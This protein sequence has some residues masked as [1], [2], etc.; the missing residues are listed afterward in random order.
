MPKTPAPPT[1][2]L[3]RAIVSGH[4][5]TVKP[6]LQLLPKDTH[7]SP[8]I[9]GLLSRPYKPNQHNQNLQHTRGP[10][11]PRDAVAGV[12][13]QAT[14]DG[15]EQQHE[16]R[17]DP[18]VPLGV[19][20][21]EQLRVAEQV[22]VDAGQHDAGEGV[23]LEGAAGDGLAARLEGH[24]RDGH[25]DVPGDLVLGVAAGAE[26]H[27]GGGG[28]AQRRLER[29]AGDERPAPLGA[30]AAVEPAEEEGADAEA[31]ERG[32]GLDPPGALRGRREAEPDVDGVACD[33]SQN[34]CVSLVV[35]MRLAE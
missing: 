14:R 5:N 23:V 4:S 35:C 6:R 10:Q 27:D 3:T 20:E 7:P 29:E 18:A 21:A 8:S 30:E 12:R 2:A 17:A 9:I 33:A 11:R 32:P 28:D 16:R 25:Q 22:A 31:A 34:L 13:E 19:V 1:Q 24:E 15:T 26:G